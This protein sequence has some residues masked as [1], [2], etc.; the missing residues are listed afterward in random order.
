MSPISLSHFFFTLV[1]FR[2]CARSSFIITCFGVLTVLIIS[3]TSQSGTR[4][5]GS[6]IGP[7]SWSIIVERWGLDGVFNGVT[8]CLNW[9]VCLRQTP[10]ET[11]ALYD[12]VIS[13]NYIITNTEFHIQYTLWSSY[14]FVSLITENYLIIIWIYEVVF[15]VVFRTRVMQVMIGCYCGHYYDMTSSN[16][17]DTGWLLFR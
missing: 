13:H 7:G 3:V 6:D 4:D 14:N 12:T 1:D 8:L 2:F 5:W 11:L 17:Q 15:G 10:S 9:S 16:E